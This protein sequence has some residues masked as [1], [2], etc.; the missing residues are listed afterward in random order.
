MQETQEKQVRFLGQEDPLEE[1][2]AIHYSILAWK[3]PLTE[4]PGSL[5]SSPRGRKQL[6]MTERLSTHTHRLHNLS[7]LREQVSVRASLGPRSS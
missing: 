3:I 1:E 4:E 2:I 5:Q 6:D 7:K